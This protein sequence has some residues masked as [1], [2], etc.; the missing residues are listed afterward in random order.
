[1][2]NSIP[3]PW[4][5]WPENKHTGQVAWFVV[6]RRLAFMPFLWAGAVIMAL[7]II[8]A[9]GLDDAIRFMRRL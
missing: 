9:Y 1:M 2:T 4:W 3:R 8:G 6:L 7:A 5:R